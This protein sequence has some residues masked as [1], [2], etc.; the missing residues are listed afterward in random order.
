MS[1]AEEKKAFKNAFK[2]EI[3]KDLNWKMTVIELADVIVC[4]GK[5]T[6]LEEIRQY[7]LADDDNERMYI[8][9]CCYSNRVD[10]NNNKHKM[11]FV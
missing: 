8:V 11:F 10:Y 7:A 1:Y 4:A 9:I 5:N 3:D 2:T 6:T